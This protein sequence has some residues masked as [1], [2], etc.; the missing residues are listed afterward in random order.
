MRSYRQAERLARRLEDLASSATAR[1]GVADLDLGSALGDFNVYSIF[2]TTKENPDGVLGEV[3]KAIKSFTKTSELAQKE[4]PKVSEPVAAAASQIKTIT[5]NAD[6]WRTD[7]DTILT[8]V[9]EASK[10]APERLEQIGNILE[11]AERVATPSNVDRLNDSIE[12]FEATTDDL[13]FFANDLADGEINERLNALL[14]SG[15]EAM[16]HAEAA[17]SKF[18]FESD[19]I[20]ADLT[21]PAIQLRDAA[22]E[23]RRSPWRLVYRPTADELNYEVLY[24]AVRMYANAV[25]ELRSTS[26]ELE[27]LRESLDDRQNLDEE[28]RA[29]LSAVIERAQG[30]TDRYRDAEDTFNRLLQGDSE[31]PAEE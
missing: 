15:N 5:A 20:L 8:K 18:R 29:R 12:N 10:V 3:D 26:S 14:D 6:Q 23:V 27:S 17:I 28:D 22:I 21:L 1:I 19:D 4:L 7:I 11:Q 9:A 24:D 30:A 31:T 2:D 16:M 25:T 13:R